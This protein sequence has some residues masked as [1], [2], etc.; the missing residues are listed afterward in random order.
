MIAPMKSN[1][2]TAQIT[3]YILLG[4]LALLLVLIA[5][6][7]LEWRAGYDP[8]WMLYDGRLID[9]H[10]LVPYRDFHE[11]NLP[12]SLYL[13]L[14]IGRVIGFTNERLL[15]VID[16][17]C[18]G[19]LGLATWFWLRPL[20]HRVACGAAVL[21][22]IAYLASDITVNIQRDY[23]I[24]LPLVCAAAIAVRLSH[25]SLVTRGLLIG[26]LGG[27]A[28]TIK[29]HALIG[30]L[31][32]LGFMYFDMQHEQQ[33]RRFIAPIVKLGFSSLVGLLIPIGLMVLYLASSGS[34]SDF[35]NIETQYVP[36]YS[37][38]SRTLVII[39]F[40]ERIGYMLRSYVGFDGLGWWFIPAGIGVVSALHITDQGHSQHR[41]VW[42]MVGLAVC[43]SLYPAVSG[44][45]FNYHWLPF[46]YFLMALSALSLNGLPASVPSMLRWLPSLA[47]IGG[48][49]LPP[50]PVP[51]TLVR[52]DSYYIQKQP[53]PP[54]DGGVA[55]ELATYL[56]MHRQP[57][58]RVQVLG[59]SGTP[60][61]G[62]LL[63][64][65]LPATYFLLDLPLHHDL[66]Q[67]TIQKYQQV[68][69]SQLEHSPPRFV[70]DMYQRLFFIG[71]DS[72]VDLPEFS[73]WLA[74][75]YQLAYVSRS[76]S[77]YE[78]HPEIH[79]GFVVY[80]L[81]ETDI[82]VRYHLQA[83]SDVLPLNREQVLDAQ[84]VNDNLSDF[85]N[86]YDIISAEFLA[87]Q[88]PERA[89]EGWLNQHAFRTG[90]YWIKGT[91]I[92]EYVTATPECL[93]T[94]TSSITFG[95]SIH[96]DRYATAL[97]KRGGTRWACIRLEWST[98]QPLADSYKFSVRVTN[99][100]GQVVAAYD[101]QPA[102][103][104]APTTT[105]KPGETIYDQLALPLPATLTTDHYH[106]ELVVYNEVS[107]AQLPIPGLNG[108]P[109]L[110]PLGDILTGD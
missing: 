104:L 14:L 85:V 50:S 2:T 24:I 21:F 39:D 23:F 70:V 28:A 77:I 1:I 31:A 79:R 40:P 30:W 8:A 88:D 72:S 46:M 101:S 54:T 7:S 95:P 80:P 4:L 82:P 78:H 102:G 18:L 10:H 15:R 45:F 73:Q 42:L 74:K 11:I 43:Y 110:L 32:I 37:H 75:N 19:V 56:L 66:S 49:V 103:Y 89:I 100:E 96:L 35:I 20:G 36:L 81:E 98:T 71:P 25:W 68:F 86:R 107:G 52:L 83:A 29:P 57:E 51:D 76:F 53:I 60:L 38:V 9:Q 108:T 6:Y 106:V 27:L 84:I 26:V 16:L 12:G 41:Q 58:D 55:D 62:L 94:R 105:W 22:G 13:Y 87:E 92:V 33:P 67:P 3:S 109:D 5:V 90:E 47:L 44:Q 97:T 48:L 69:M 17:A 63:A 61:H 34:L 64:D 99:L 93:E 65:A 91:R 59:S